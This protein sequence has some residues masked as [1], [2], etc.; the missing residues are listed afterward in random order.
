MFSHPFAAHS[1][2]SAAMCSGL[3]SYSPNSLGSPAFGYAL[4]CVSAIPESS[5]MYCRS[6]F[7]PKA[8]FRPTLIGF[9]WRTEFQNASVTWPE[10]V[11]PLASVMVP[12]IMMGTSSPSS[13]R[14]SV[15]PKIAAFAFS[16]S[17]MV[18][19]SS[20]SAPPSTSPRAASLYASFNSSKVMF[21]KPGLFTSGDREAVR[22]VGPKAPATKRGLSGVFPV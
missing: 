10:R 5:S 1:P 22:L 4:T 9:A 7:E 18:S 13:S 14:Y 20:R 3:S 12:E 21:R 2:I 11:R 16:V 6:S 15:T 19:M 8:Q 17:K